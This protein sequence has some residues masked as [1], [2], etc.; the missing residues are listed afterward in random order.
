MKLFSKF[1]HTNHTHTHRN[2]DDD[3]E[4][5]DE[6]NDY[7]LDLITDRPYH[8]LS[9]TIRAPI[10]PAIV[11]ISN[12]PILSSTHIQYET[13]TTTPIPISTTTESTSTTTKTTTRKPSPKTT[14][15]VAP[16]TI[17]YNRD[18]YYDTDIDLTTLAPQHTNS[19]SSER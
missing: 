1:L 3:D 18:D 17:P 16:T 5:Y 4:Q 9:S 19:P 6:N 8:V 2:H 12:S 7:D 13:E 10:R 15:T 11:P 14:T